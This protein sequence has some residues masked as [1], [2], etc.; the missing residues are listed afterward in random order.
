[1]RLMYLKE[2]SPLYVADSIIKEYAPLKDDYRTLRNIVLKYNVLQKND[3]LLLNIK[4]RL[5][6][7]IEKEKGLIGMLLTQNT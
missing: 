2:H 4:S 3:K 6:S 5:Q 7:A 1:M